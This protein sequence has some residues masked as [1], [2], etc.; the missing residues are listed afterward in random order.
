M[1]MLCQIAFEPWLQKDFFAI[2]AHYLNLDHWSYNLSPPPVDNYPNADKGL[3][4]LK[5]LLI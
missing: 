4:K 2:L 1:E 5:A 3:Y